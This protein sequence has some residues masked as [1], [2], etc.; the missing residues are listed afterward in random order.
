[1]NDS[2]QTFWEMSV[3]GLGRRFVAD[4]LL[5]HA[6]AQANT[7]MTFKQKHIGRRIYRKKKASEKLQSQ[8]GQ[9]TSNISTL[10]TRQHAENGVV[11]LR[12]RSS[13]RP[14]PLALQLTNSM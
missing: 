12:L 11:T 14:H 2:V 3:D 5:S 4:G 7:T 13:R 8:K 6:P 9:H 10:I 1:M